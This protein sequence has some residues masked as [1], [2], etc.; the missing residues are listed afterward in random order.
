MIE[1]RDDK[2][3]VIRFARVPVS[4]ASDNQYSFF[5]FLKHGYRLSVERVVRQARLNEQAEREETDLLAWFR[6]SAEK[7]LFSFSRSVF[8]SAY[9]YDKRLLRF[10]SSNYLPRKAYLCNGFANTDAMD[11][12]YRPRKGPV[13]TRQYPTLIQCVSLRALPGNTIQFYRQFSR[14]SKKRIYQSIT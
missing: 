4:F 6:S 8:R 9:Y 5:F 13:K 14:R 7:F 1:A 3:C 11:N 2:V 12:I 10:N